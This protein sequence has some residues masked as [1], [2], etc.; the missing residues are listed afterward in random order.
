M[1]IYL[2]K[3]K[4]PGR[5]GDAQFIGNDRPCLIS[6]TSSRRRVKLCANPPS[7]RRPLTR[8]LFRGHRQAQMTLRALP[9]LAFPLFAFCPLFWPMQREAMI[10][11][12][13]S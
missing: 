8:F 3:G 12:T 5:K 1:G 11:S 6:A 7:D 2:G 13:G 4:W 10:L 9:R